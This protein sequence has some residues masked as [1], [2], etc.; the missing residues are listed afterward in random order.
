MRFFTPQ[1]SQG[2]QSYYRGNHQGN[3]SV[4]NKVNEVIFTKDNLPGQTLGCSYLS[5]G[6]CTGH[7]SDCWG[8]HGLY[9]SLFCEIKIRLS[10]YQESIQKSG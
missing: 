3:I 7:R 5:A 9:L 4:D 2:L 6:A 1:K 8:V 10:M